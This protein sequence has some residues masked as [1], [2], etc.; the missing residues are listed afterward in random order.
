MD[1]SSLTEYT[2]HYD[3]ISFHSYHKNR[4]GKL[5]FAAQ[6]LESYNEL[7]YDYDFLFGQIDG[8]MHLQIGFKDFL[9]TK[10]KAFTNDW[11]FY[12]ITYER[13]TW[14]SPIYIYRATR[15]EQ[16]YFM[17]ASGQIVPSLGKAIYNLFL[18]PIAID[19]CWKW[20]GIFLVTDSEDYWRSWSDR[21]KMI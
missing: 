6:P 1:S 5:F 11:A 12:M 17:Q 4:L 2:R 19:L 3:A 10:T 20:Q 15:M 14:N 7:G 18:M 8:E 16:S 13:S 21:G 9:F